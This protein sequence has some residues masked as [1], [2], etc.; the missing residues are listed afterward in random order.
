[1]RGWQW[2]DFQPRPGQERRASQGISF[3]RV[4][5][6]RVL[7]PRPM[8]YSPVRMAG[9][10]LRGEPCSSWCPPDQASGIPLPCCRSPTSSLGSIHNHSLPSRNQERPGILST[11][12]IVH[13]SWVPPPSL[14]SV[15]RKVG[16]VGWVESSRPTG[17]AAAIR[18]VSKTRPTLRLRRR[19]RGRR[20]Q[21]GGNRTSQGIGGRLAERDVEFKLSAVVVRDSLQVI[22]AR[23][24]KQPK[25]VEDLDGQAFQ[26][27]GPSEIRLEASFACLDRLFSDLQLGETSMGPRVGCR[28]LGGARG[29]GSRLPPGCSFRAAPWLP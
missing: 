6:S 28:H 23:Q 20:D 19:H 8:H 15:V 17:W 21:G 25:V 27:L 10:S 3:A 9:L 14:K 11:A 2:S 18:W 24:A 5:G 29:S 16:R 7:P 12:S 13:R 4:V 1:M 22:Q 26:T